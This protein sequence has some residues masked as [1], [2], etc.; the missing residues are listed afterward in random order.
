M[1]AA[2]RKV[3]VRRSYR[4]KILEAAEHADDVIADAVEPRWTI[5]R[6]SRKHLQIIGTNS[7]PPAMTDPPAECAGKR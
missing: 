1:H 5:A 4:A 7:P 3:A 6:L 2:A